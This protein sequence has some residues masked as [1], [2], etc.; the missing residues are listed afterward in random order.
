MSSASWWRSS[1]ASSW[2]VGLVGGLMP[3]ALFAAHS[4]LPASGGAS[5]RALL[6]LLVLLVGVLVGLEIPLVMR[7][8]KRHFRERYALKDLV[9]Q[10]LTFDYL[11]A[12][13]VAVAFPLLLLPQLGLVRTGVLFGLLNAAVAV[14]ALWLFRGEL[15]ALARQRAGVRRG[16]R[17]A[18]RRD[19]R[20]RCAHQLGRGPVLSATA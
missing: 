20:R 7:I 19:G 8:L 18:G 17:D 1:C 5:F 13:V 12:L 10:V 4:V 14:W 11:G 9:S 3:A 15:R 2:L 16:R 6:Y